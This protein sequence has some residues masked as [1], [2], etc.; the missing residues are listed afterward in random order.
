MK[1]SGT[2]A[3]LPLVKVQVERLEKALAVLGSILTDLEKRLEPCL[4]QLDKPREVAPDNLP[5]T[6]ESLGAPLANDLGTLNNCLDI[7][8]GR[9]GILKERVEL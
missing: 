3:P 7:A 9:V 4:H 1:E 8:I 5:T 2:T 6:E